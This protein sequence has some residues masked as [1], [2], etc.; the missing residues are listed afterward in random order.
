MILSTYI[1]KM[2]CPNGHVY[3]LRRRATSAGKVI[4]SRC[5]VCHK[6][7]DQ[8]A[9]PLPKDAAAG[10]TLERHIEARLVKRV[11]ELGGEVRKVKW[12]GRNGAPDRLVM[13][14][15][16]WDG[17]L[18]PNRDHATIW[19]EM[20]APGGLAKFPKNAHERAQHRE[21]ERMRRLGQRVEVVDSYEQIE[22]L[23]K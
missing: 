14:P 11:T 16:T 19:V 9:S 17:C 10:P 21:H 7:F 5:P 23:L 22:E 8:V 3:N 4:R 15:Q 6:V 2:K 20:K 1:D 12:I 13:L 18:T